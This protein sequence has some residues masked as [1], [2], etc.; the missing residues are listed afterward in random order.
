MIK[1]IFFALWYGSIIFSVPLAGMIKS[2]EDR[3]TLTIEEYTQSVLYHYPAFCAFMHVQELS[4]NSEKGKNEHCTG[5]QKQETLVP[6]LQRTN[7]KLVYDVRKSI[8][9]LFSPWGVFAFKIF[10]DMSFYDGLMVKIGKSAKLQVT[11]YNHS[12]L[13]PNTINYD[14]ENPTSLISPVIKYEFERVFVADEGKI[15]VLRTAS[16]N[17]LKQIYGTKGDYGA[18][19]IHSEF[20]KYGTDFHRN[21]TDIIAA[22]LYTE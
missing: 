7:M 20:Q 5:W 19:R 16:F 12:L 6:E 1:N 11:P 10:R 4:Q 8:I 14:G 2:S 9:E 15:S 18:Q 22:Y 13:Y 21:V 17:E 3:P